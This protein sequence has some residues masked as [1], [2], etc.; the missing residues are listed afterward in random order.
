[1]NTPGNTDPCSPLTP[2]IFLFAYSNDLNSSIVTNALDYF[3]NSPSAHYPLQ[4][5]FRFD[6]QPGGEV[7]WTYSWSD[8]NTTVR[9]TLPDPSLSFTSN[10]TGSDLF[11]TLYTFLEFSNTLCGGRAV[12]LVK[13]YPN[14]VDVSYYTS[15]FRQNHFSISFL[16]SSSPSGGNHPETLYNLAS[17]TN[18]LCAYSVDS[19]MMESLYGLP[20][21]FYPYQ[22]Y[23]VN[24]EVSDEGVITLPPLS[25][26]TDGYQK[27]LFTMTVT[28]NGTARDVER[29][30]LGWL[31]VQGGGQL[32]DDGVYTDGDYVGNKISKTEGLLKT[33]YDMTYDYTYF[34]RKE[35]RVQIRIHGK[36]STGIST[37]PPFDN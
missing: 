13:R 33:M 14:E 36:N 23:A 35:K 3:V 2:T 25:V 15:F 4:A 17:K 37:F 32:G 29:A 28:D 27:Y 19:R 16:V 7:Q 5:T 6:T 18:G 12:I 11:H 10:S 34:D 9:A 30:L 26:F 31:S 21:V 24:P 20:T 8:F 22:V 1:M